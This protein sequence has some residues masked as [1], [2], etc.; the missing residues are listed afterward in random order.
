VSDA[1]LLEAFEQCTLS[2]SAFHHEDHIRVAFLY[3]SRLP[4]LQAL[5][6]FRDSLVRFAETHGKAGLYNETVTWAYILIIRERMARAGRAQDWSE[7]KAANP[8]LFDRG[9]DLLRRYYRSETLTSALAKS[10]FLFPDNL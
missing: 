2:N 6:R 4:A 10:T 3:L 7:F 1:E 9:R 8:D 5:Q